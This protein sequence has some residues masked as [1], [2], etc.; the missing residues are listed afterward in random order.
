[1]ESQR[2]TSLTEMGPASAAVAIAAFAI[3]TVVDA[4]A[5]VVAVVG[6]PSAS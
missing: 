2:E 6:I 3:A 5:A 1:M 4:T